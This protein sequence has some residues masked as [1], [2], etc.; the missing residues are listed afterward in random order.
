LK[1]FIFKGIL[2]PKAVRTIIFLQTALS[3]VIVLALTLFTHYSFIGSILFAL[4]FKAYEYTIVFVKRTLGIT[5]GSEVER[6]IV[7]MIGF[8]ILAY[9][10]PYNYYPLFFTFALTTIYY[11]ASIIFFVIFF[12]HLSEIIEL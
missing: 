5:S 9:F 8:Y 1:E 2:S 11:F 4:V 7:T 6:L 10:G 12:K 3:I